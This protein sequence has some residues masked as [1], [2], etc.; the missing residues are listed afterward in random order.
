MGADFILGWLRAFLLTQAV[1]MGVYAQASA[2]PLRERLGIAF[3]ASAITHPIV[4]FVIPELV[5]AWGPSGAWRTDW[6]IA[7]GIAE[8]FAV[9]AEALWLG[10]FGKPPGEAIAWSLAANAASFTIGLFLYLY[11]GW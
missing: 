10:V 8:V 1:E 5:R 3:A 9:T 6:W 7:V 11:M 2:R 4:W